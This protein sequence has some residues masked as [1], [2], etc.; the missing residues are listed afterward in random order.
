[1]KVRF[2]V[3]PWKIRLHYHLGDVAILPKEQALELIEMGY[4]ELIEEVELPK[5]Q[6][7]AANNKK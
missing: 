6:K 2:I 4:C 5:I 1:M 7:K 3:K